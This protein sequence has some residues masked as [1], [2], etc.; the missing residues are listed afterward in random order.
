VRVGPGLPYFEVG[1]YRYTAEWLPAVGDI[2]TVTKTVA[3]DEEVPEQMLAYVTQ[4]N[5]SSDTPIRVTH[6]KGVSSS[7]PDDYIVAA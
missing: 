7:S 2:V 6:A 5:P 3:T 1:A 4:V